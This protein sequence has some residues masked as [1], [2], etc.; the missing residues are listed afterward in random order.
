MVATAK[1]CHSWLVAGCRVIVNVMDQAWTMGVNVVDGH[2]ARYEVWDQR[3][4][5][6]FLAHATSLKLFILMDGR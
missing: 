2:H 5:R 6:F 4:D 1:K 3:I